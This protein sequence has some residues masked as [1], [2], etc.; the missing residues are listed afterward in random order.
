MKSYGT[1]LRE[2]LKENN[3]T[4]KELARR[5]G[6]TQSRVSKY[7]RDEHTPGLEL[8]RRINEAIYWWGDES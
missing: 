5:I 8:V 7:V 3:I 4:Q 1:I 6:S 2:M